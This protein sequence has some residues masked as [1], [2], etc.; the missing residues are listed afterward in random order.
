MELE[1]ESELNR[2]VDC[3]MKMIEE[4]AINM[5]NIAHIIRALTMDLTQPAEEYINNQV[6]AAIITCTE[7]K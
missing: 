6:R 2:R 7:S 4:K 5:D 3:I 1:Q